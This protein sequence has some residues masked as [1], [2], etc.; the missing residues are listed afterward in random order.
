MPGHKNAPLTPEGRKRLCERVAAGRAIAHVAAEAGVSRQTLAKWYGR[1]DQFGEA[2][3]IDQSSRPGR[4]PN[5][6]DEDVVAMIL[7]I[8]Q[9]EKWGAQRIAA[10]LER[11]DV[12]IAPATVHRVLERN[13]MGR[14]RDMDPPTG[15]QMRGVVRYEHERAG[16]MVHVDVKKIGKIPKGGGWRVHGKGTDEHRASK[17]KATTRAGYTYLHTAIDDYSR[18]AYTEALENEKGVTAAQFWLR[19]VAFFAEHGIVQPA[20]PIWTS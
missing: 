15:E 3:L 4:S 19:A 11:N 2:G 6:T 7:A 12:K 9:T 16:D 14:L 18:L 5:A 20:T 10:Y 8:R 1:F 17:R 13:G